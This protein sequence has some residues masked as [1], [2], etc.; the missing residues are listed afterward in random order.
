MPY[1]TT[2][3]IRSR[4]VHDTKPDIFGL[5]RAW[6]Q[7]SRCSWHIISLYFNVGIVRGF[8]CVSTL[9]FAGA[10]GLARLARQHDSA[11]VLQAIAKGEGKICVRVYVVITISFIVPAYLSVL[12]NARRSAFHL[13]VPNHGGNQGGN[14]FI[15]YELYALRPLHWNTTRA[16]RH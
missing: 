15:P 2:V 8:V 1:S 6:A 12:T 14:H 4:I 5:Y 16:C 11:R 9:I 7:E 10:G 13:N 3:G